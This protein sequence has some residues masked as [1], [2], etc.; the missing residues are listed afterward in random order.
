MS[1]IDKLSTIS[2]TL[3]QLFRY[4]LDNEIIKNDF[5]EYLKTIGAYNAKQSEINSILV[6]YVFERTFNKGSD[7]V[8]NMFLNDSNDLDKE[9]IE[10]VQALQKSIDSLFEVKSVKSNGFELY[11]LVNE[12]DYYAM[13][14]VKMSHLKGIYKG[15]YILARIFPFEGAYY[16]IE[17]RE[18]YS[19]L[20][21]D[22]VLKYA[23]AK[24]IEQP[25]NLYK[26]ND[27][28]LQEVEEEISKFT[29]KF[30]DCFGS[31]EI[32]TTNEYVD[33]LISEFNDY[34]YD[35]SKD[36]DAIKD[37]IKPIEKYGY[38]KVPEFN[39][40]Y[41]NYIETS[42][43]GF[44]SHSSKYDVGVIF[45]K[46]L[47]MYIVPF[48]GTICEILK[49][50]NYKEI[51]GWEECIKSFMENDKIPAKL[52][53]RLNEKYPNFIKILNEIYASD[54]TINEFL[55]EFKQDYLSKKI[56]SPTS[57]LYSSKTFSDLMGFIPSE[58]EMKA[59]QIREDNK[60]IGRNEPC[61]CG[62]GKKYKKCCG[63]MI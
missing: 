27:N 12:K 52:V 1:V 9:T 41:D 7:T 57:V 60:N 54:K 5:D 51:S 56:F 46:E 45:E 59:K 55:A 47:G 35:S 8:F 61:P 25:E 38:F 32:I 63:A 36:C 33:Q 14:L 18:T 10:V 42:M 6:T 43:A 53:E 21:K 50:T 37:L 28:K 22:K 31:D 13:P 44:S 4:A 58:E 20:D 19:S 48:Y 17:I 15:N 16:I 23:V 49:S 3:S 24:I 39:S 40:S 34:Y 29:S 30:V 11:S 26:D 2:E 62:S